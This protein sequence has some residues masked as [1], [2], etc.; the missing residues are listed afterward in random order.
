LPVCPLLCV[1]RS[2]MAELQPASERGRD[3]SQ[4][5]PTLDLMS[6]D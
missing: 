3:E 5:Y 6:T 2:C 4:V 1:C